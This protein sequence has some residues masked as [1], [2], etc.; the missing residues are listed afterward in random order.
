ME[1]YLYLYAFDLFLRNF[2]HEIYKTFL[3]SSPLFFINVN[4]G[5]FIE[6][7]ELYRTH[8]FIQTLLHLPQSHSELF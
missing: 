4:G 2:S 1:E 5:S 8:K 3:N 7:N 6:I